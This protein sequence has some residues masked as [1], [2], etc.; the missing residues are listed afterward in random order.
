[1]TAPL[2]PHVLAAELSY[3]DAERQARGCANPVRLTGSSVTVNEATGEVVGTYSS[4]DA[5]DGHVYVRCGN[6]RASVCPSCSREYKGDAWHLLACG[7][8]GG[9]DVPESVV[10]HPAT[11]LTLTAPSFGAVHRHTRPGGTGKTPPCRARRDKP[12]CAHGRPLWC[13]RRHDADDT[14]NGLPLCRDCYDYTAHVAWQWHAPE[15]WRRFTIALH[16]HLAATLGLTVKELRDRCRVAY[17]KVVEF[18]ARGAIH[19]HA[20]IRLDGPE[21]PATPPPPELS[22]THLENAVHA[23]AGQV[24]YDAPIGATEALTLRWGTQIDTRTITPGA[25]RDGSHG[26]AHPHQ[27]AAYLSKYLTKSTEDFGLPN[28]G[29]IRHSLHARAAGASPHAIRIIKTAEQLVGVHEDYARLAD[30]YATL[31]YRGHPI[32]KS[33]AYSVTFTTLRATPRHWRRRAAR[34]PTHAAVR[35]V[36]DTDHDQDDTTDTEIVIGEWRYAGRGYLDMHTATQAVFSAV[37]S[38]TRRATQFAE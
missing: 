25:G 19:I 11:F 31:G 9:K 24:T 5:A 32:T 15:L 26:P 20:A 30:R 17:A 8:V 33:R 18:Q 22:V 2:D 6:R 23:A 3:A 21:G 4:D 36:L 27:V 38:R 16:R 12:V 13:G 14:Q 1:M 10:D 37:Q 34:L 29:R 35:D 28:S 7:L